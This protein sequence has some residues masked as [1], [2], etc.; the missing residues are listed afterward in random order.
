ML[1][2]GSLG[3]VWWIVSFYFKWV[4]NMEATIIGVCTKKGFT[5]PRSMRMNIMYIH[6]FSL[7]FSTGAFIFYVVGQKGRI[8]LCV[9]VPL[10]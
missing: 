8:W 10:F 6:T 4:A 2:Y 9:L 7:D 5:K 3:F 1:L